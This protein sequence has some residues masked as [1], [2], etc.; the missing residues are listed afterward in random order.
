MCYSFRNASKGE[1]FSTDKLLVTPIP[2]VSIETNAINT[3]IKITEG[4]KTISNTNMPKRLLAISAMMMPVIEASIP[5]NRY[6]L[7][8]IVNTWRRLAPKVRKS[9]FS[10]KR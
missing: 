9:T 5:N 2:A 7:A 3:K 10:L 6:S 4:T 8:V 1:R